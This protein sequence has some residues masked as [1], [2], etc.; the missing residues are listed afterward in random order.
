MPYISWTL[1][2][3]LK[4]TPHQSRPALPHLVRRPSP[5]DTDSAIFDKGTAS[6]RSAPTVADGTQQFAQHSAGKC[7]M[8]K[9]Y[10]PDPDQKSGGKLSDAGQ[11]STE[12]STAHER[13]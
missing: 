2:S 5:P 11:A 4:G 10:T 12:A 9:K 3:P 7:A 1:V 8:K 6:L 13:I